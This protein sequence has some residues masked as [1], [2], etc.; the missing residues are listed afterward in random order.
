MIILHTPCPFDTQNRGWEWND[1]KRCV[2]EAIRCKRWLGRQIEDSLPP[3][4][5]VWPATT[6]SKHSNAFW[7]TLRQS[8]DSGLPRPR[9]SVGL[10]QKLEIHVSMHIQL[11]DV[12][13]A[14]S[15]SL[16]ASNVHTFAFCLARLS[17]ALLCFIQ[18]GLLQSRRYP[19]LLATNKRIDPKERRRTFDEG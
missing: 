3:F 4:A 8:R 10:V 5:H 12:A 14:R 17:R 9:S 7:V 6:L 19:R 2:P 15:C 16:T 18:F 1:L 13:S 11:Q